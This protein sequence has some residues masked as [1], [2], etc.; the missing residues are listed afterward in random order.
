MIATIG[1]GQKI[2]IPLEYMKDLSLGVGSKV[3]LLKEGN[4]IIILPV[5]EELDNFFKKKHKRMC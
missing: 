3:M 4:K 1:K 5:D 2:R